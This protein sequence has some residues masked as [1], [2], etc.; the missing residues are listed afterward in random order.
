MPQG[1]EVIVEDGFATIH[2]PDREVRADVLRR[3][4]AATPPR[5]IETQTRT[6]PNVTYRVPEGN[7]REA[8]LLDG[9]AVDE[10]PHGDSGFAAALLAADR[11]VNGARLPLERTVGDDTYVAGRDGN[12]TI[13]GPLHPNHPAVDPKDVP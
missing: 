12:A 6:G 8:G 13:T 5:L 1:V 2:A 9:E 11:S 10:L 7:A 4:L 3:L